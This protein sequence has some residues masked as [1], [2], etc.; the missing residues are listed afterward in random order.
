MDIK[1]DFNAHATEEAAVQ[2]GPDAV[3]AL[4]EAYDRK[5]KTFFASWITAQPRARAT[6]SPESGIAEAIRDLPGIAIDHDDF[7]RLPIFNFEVQKRRLP[8]GRAACM[9]FGDV[10]LVYL[11][12][13]L[14]SPMIYRVDVL[15]GR[16]EA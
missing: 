5:I 2:A 1:V 11:V 4:L 14:Q 12:G 3:R 6:F 15:E 7:E 9:R 10:W 13:I 16:S 8:T